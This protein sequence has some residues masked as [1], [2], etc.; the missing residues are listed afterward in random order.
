LIGGKST[1]TIWLGFAEDLNGDG[2]V[3]IKDL[4]IVAKAFGSY[5]G[6]PN[7][8]PIADVTGSTLGVPDNK[9]DIRDVAYVAKNFGKIYP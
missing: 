4:A 3:D 8:N 2:K 7:W 1:A 9:V 5:L 6:S